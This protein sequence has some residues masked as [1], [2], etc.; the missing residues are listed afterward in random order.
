M[1]TPHAAGATALLW[2]L[3]RRSAAATIRARLDELAADAG[4]PGRD[5]QYGFG[6]LDLARIGG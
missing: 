4:A 5:P 3:H 2:D 6:V 1:A